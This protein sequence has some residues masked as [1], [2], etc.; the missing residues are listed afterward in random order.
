MAIQRFS[1]GVLS[2]LLHL[3]AGAGTEAGGSVELRE[4]MPLRQS[5]EKGDS[6]FVGGAGAVERG[7]PSGTLVKGSSSGDNGAGVGI[8]GMR[9][10]W[11]VVCPRLGSLKQQSVYLG[12]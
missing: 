10:R 8:E 1:G 9:P 4:S 2:F 3:G 12:F 6:R 11:R 7:E 5:F